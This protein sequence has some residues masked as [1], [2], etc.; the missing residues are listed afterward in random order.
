LS[1]ANIYFV[2]DTASNGDDGEDFK[3]AAQA[4]LSMQQE[5][6]QVL[7]LCF[8]LHFPNVKLCFFRV[9]QK[10]IPSRIMGLHLRKQ[11]PRR[12]RQ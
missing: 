4:L 7:S 1:R 9:M 6:I 12:A 8:D 5:V 2:L 10:L 11:L 3:V